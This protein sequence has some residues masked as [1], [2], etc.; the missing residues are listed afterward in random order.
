MILP[1]VQ[2]I[3]RLLVGGE[4]HA[5]ALIERGRTVGYGELAAMVDAAAARLIAEG[6]APGDRVAV[7]A[8]KSVTMVAA[9]FAV[10]RAGGVA[11]PINPVLRAGQVAHILAD[12]GARLLLTHPGRA[13]MLAKADALGPARALDLDTLSVVLG[14][15]PPNP[16]APGELAALLYTSGSTGR[17]KG[18]MLS[19][20]NLWL[21]ADSVRM[22]MGIAADDRALAVLPLSFDAGLSVLTSAWMAGGAVTLLDY[23]V[24]RDVLLAVNQHRITT[25]SAV[26]PLLVQ[27]AEADWREAASLRRITVTGGRMP[28]RVTRVLRAALPHTRLFLMYGLTEAF[29]SLY[30]DPALVDAHPDSVGGPIPYAQVSLVRADGTV[31]ADGVPGEL[32]HAGPLVAM[33]Y[34][35]DPDAT[36]A[37]FRPGPDGERTVWSGDTLV[38][39]PQGLHRFVA[40]ADEMIK[41]SGFRVSP[42]DIEEAAHA[43]GAVAECAAFGMSDERLGEAIVLMAVA[44]GDEPEARLML[45]LA[46][47]LPAYM[48]PTRID[49]RAQLPR[50]PNGK[51][52]RAALR[53]DLGL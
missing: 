15:P 22:F 4:R 24:P 5:P 47:T 32:V 20:A 13:A 23:L 12:S 11:V 38:R 51:I 48:R 25:L 9:L 40:R 53:A 2:T 52:D 45:G 50:S 29:R 33:G 43:T 44:V 39:D 31:S 8:P 27:L 6:Q 42:T 16:R 36:A 26:P 28:V 21:A 14:A 34:W 19:H 46:Q 30:L 35:N 18:V 37:R 49:W 17:P 3:D 41:T 10:W 7:Y 1:T